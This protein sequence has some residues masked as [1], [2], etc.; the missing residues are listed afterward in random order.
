MIKEKVGKDEEE[1]KSE[2]I[3]QY[4]NRDGIIRDK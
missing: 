3:K 2:Q 4:E 1:K